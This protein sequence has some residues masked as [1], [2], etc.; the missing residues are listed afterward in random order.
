MKELVD[1][2]LGI[3]IAIGLL[4][5]LMTIVFSFPRKPMRFRP[6]FGTICASAITIS[7]VV[8]TF[9][10]PYIGVS[11]MGGFLVLGDQTNF[12]GPPA[13]IEGV[14]YDP[15]ALTKIGVAVAVFFFFVAGIDVVF[16]I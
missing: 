13:R 14:S 10:Q 4:H 1:T 3:A 16:D 9:L 12:L 2:P 6:V 11:L 5:V 15:R 7:C 8:G